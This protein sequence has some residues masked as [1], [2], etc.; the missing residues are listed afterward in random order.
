MTLCL[1]PMFIKQC[2]Y[3]SHL[4]SLMWLQWQIVG[5]LLQKMMHKIQDYKHIMCLWTI[6]KVAS[7]SNITKNNIVCYFQT[8]SYMRHIEM[9]LQMQYPFPC[10]KYLSLEGHDQ[11][12]SRNWGWWF[13][14]AK[15]RGSINQSSSWWGTKC[16]ID[17]EPLK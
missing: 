5:C 10:H 3:F 15:S 16:I 8:S 14:W 17:L 2:V 1:V 6:I 9:H 4:V 11:L 13:S 12:C 7:F